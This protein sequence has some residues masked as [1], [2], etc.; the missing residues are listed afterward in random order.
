M[1][2]IKTMN[3][4]YYE[5]DG[6]PKTGDVFFFGNPGAQSNTSLFD[7]PTILYGMAFESCAPTN[8]YNIDKIIELTD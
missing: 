5:I 3:L 8:G 4:Q 2:G 1:L 7:N 6:I